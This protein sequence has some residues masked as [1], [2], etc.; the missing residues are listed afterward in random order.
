MLNGL[1]VERT[2]IFFVIIMKASLYMLHTSKGIT[3]I[4]IVYYIMVK[5]HLICG[6]KN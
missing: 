6:G 4:W 1:M 2:Y 3:I 5:Y